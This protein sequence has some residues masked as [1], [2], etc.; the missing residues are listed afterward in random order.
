MVIAIELLKR[1][2]SVG[3]SVRSLLAVTWSMSSVENNTCVII[4][5]VTSSIFDCETDELILD[6]C[7]DAIVISSI[8]GRK[9]SSEVE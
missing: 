2:S 5:L 4:S 9:S 8:V 1:L 7:I 6:D 3:S